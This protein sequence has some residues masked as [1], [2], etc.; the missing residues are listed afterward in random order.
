[1]STLSTIDRLIAGFRGFRSLHY[2]RRP[3][4]FE[5][6]KWRQNPEVMVVACSD[7]RVDP[8]VLTQSE[9]GDLFVVRNVA[10][11]VPPYRPDGR[12][13]GTSA[14]LEF[15]V[16][17][18][19]VGHVVVLG[20]SQCGGIRALVDGLER[21]GAEREFIGPWMEVIGDVCGHEWAAGGGDRSDLRAIEQAGIRASIDNLMG[22]PWIRERVED[23]RLGLHGWW[24]ELASGELWAVRAVGEQPARLA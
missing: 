6:L 16:R 4:L 17:D 8:A 12:H 20:H 3:A 5:R 24:F 11:I 18:L 14:S 7:S 1:M 10:N 15:A 13:H 23:H 2:E 19:G 21:P 9:P 22:Y